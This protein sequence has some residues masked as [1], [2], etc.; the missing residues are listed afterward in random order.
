MK[1][2]TPTMR[3]MP[4]SGSSM[5]RLYAYRQEMVKRGKPRGDFMS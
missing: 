4:P 3:K 2:V 1:W 5:T